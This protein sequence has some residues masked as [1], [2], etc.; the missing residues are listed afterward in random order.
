MAFKK[1]IYF[2]DMNVCLPL[3]LCTTLKC[4]ACKE[5]AIWSPRTGIIGGCE[6]PSGHWEVNLDPLEEHL[7]LFPAELC[8]RVPSSLLMAF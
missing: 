1:E 3:C 6:P 8:L 7:V 5:E 2:M 4:S